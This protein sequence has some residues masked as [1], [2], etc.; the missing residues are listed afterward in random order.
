ML[1][2]W[3]SRI[4]VAFLFARVVPSSLHEDL[5]DK[6]KCLLPTVSRAQFLAKASDAISKLCFQPMF[7][8]GFCRVALD[9]LDVDLFGN[10]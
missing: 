5:L 4:G 10:Y 7:H 9:T 8:F 2:R 3:L 6:L 1:S